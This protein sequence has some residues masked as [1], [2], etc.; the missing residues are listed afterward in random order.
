M[1]LI[2]SKTDNK[3][4][5]RKLNLQFLIR[6]TQKTQPPHAAKGNNLPLGDLNQVLGCTNLT[7]ARKGSHMNQQ[8]QAVFVK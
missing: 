6:H 5:L 1:R 3:E 7:L 8:K 2:D 4:Y